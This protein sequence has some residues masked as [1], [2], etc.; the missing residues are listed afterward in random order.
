MISQIVSCPNCGQ[1]NRV[2]KQDRQVSFL[3]GACKTRL[4]DPFAID[5]TVP[6]TEP[7]LRKRLDLSKRHFQIALWAILVLVMV[8]AVSIFSKK[9]P[10][11]LPTYK[12]PQH[13][14]SIPFAKPTQNLPS[15]EQVQ[16][17]QSLPS[18]NPTQSLPRYVQNQPIQPEVPLPPPRR[19]GNGTVI[20]GLSRNGN[21]VLTID[22]GTGHDAVI[23]IVDEKYGRA[24]V[25]FY[26][27]GGQTASIENI[28]DGSFQVIFATGIDWGKEEGA[29]TRDKSF[30]KFDKNLDFLTTRG[31]EGDKEFTQYSVFTLTLHAVV[32]GNAKTTNIGEEEFLKY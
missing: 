2:Y 18:G 6:R 21:G 25:V 16:P 10:Q 13:N 3:C 19:L 4:Y 24:V 32:N 9:S 27:C 7:H 15:Y 12:Q 29:F 31:T 8:V 30:A 23:K 1:R 5:Q 22:N 17:S 28:P 11:E 26:V 14:Q 20:A